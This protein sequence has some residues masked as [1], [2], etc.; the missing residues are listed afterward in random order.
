[1]AILKEKGIKCTIDTVK[2]Y[3]NALIDIIKSDFR[4]QF[5]EKIN[6]PLGLHFHKK[7][8]IH[9]KILKFRTTTIR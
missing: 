1:M 4:Q 9:Y 7:F 5:V 2:D 6:I 8:I 3:L